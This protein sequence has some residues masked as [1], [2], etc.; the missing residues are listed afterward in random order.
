MN[1]GIWNYLASG[2][3]PKRKPEPMPQ[4]P[5]I[6]RDASDADMSEED[7]FFAA[8][9]ASYGS[10]V[11]RRFIRHRLALLGFLILLTLVLVAIL[12][13]VLAKHDPEDI[14]IELLVNGMPAPPS[15]EHIFGTDNLGRDYF[16]RICYG[17]RVSLL[18]GFA[19]TFI[20]FVIGAPIGCI[21]GYYGGKVDWVISRG[22]ELVGAVPSYFLMIFFSAVTGGGVLGT[23]LVIGLTGWVGHVRGIRA[24]FFSLKDQDFAQ[25]AKS[26]GMSVPRIMFKHILPF[27]LAPELVSVSM[28]IAGN[29]AMETGMSFLGFGVQE[30]TPSWGAMLNTAREFMITAPWMALIPAGLI[31]LVSLSC[32]FIGDGLR[33]AFDPKTRA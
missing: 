24:Y 25:A 5:V 20:S 9:I 21:A 16:S 12:T 1:N 4:L 17:M 29:L 10:M 13:P 31:A 14:H 28:R 8:R 27:A 30:P 18:V 26:M 23:I 11:F 6:V 33:D 7:A 22:M 3:L 32:N 2:I 19:S 15:A